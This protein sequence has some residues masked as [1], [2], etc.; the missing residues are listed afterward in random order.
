MAYID[1]AAEEWTSSR[2]RIADDLE[3]VLD[4]FGDGLEFGQDVKLG[5]GLLSF[6][7]YVRPVSPLEADVFERI[8]DHHLFGN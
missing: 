2:Q 6:A 3:K 7:A 4:Q 8:A 5:H 1:I